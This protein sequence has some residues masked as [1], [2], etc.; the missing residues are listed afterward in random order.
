MTIPPLSYSPSFNFC[1]YCCLHAQLS[2]IYSESTIG[3]C[4]NYDGNQGDD[5]LSPSGLVEA[6]VEDFGNSWKISGDCVD[7]VKQD[8]DPCILNP[9]RGNSQERSKQTS[10]MLSFCCE[11]VLILRWNSMTLFT[12]ININKFSVLCSGK[13][14]ILMTIKL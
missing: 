1:F 8:T 5:F 3:L 14:H 9:K 13:I 11:M 6:S 7:L 2:P 4:G 12:A 10:N